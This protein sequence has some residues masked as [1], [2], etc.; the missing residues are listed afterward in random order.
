MAVQ[1]DYG[2]FGKHTIVEARYNGNEKI[3]VQVR[4]PTDQVIEGRKLF[5]A[6]DLKNLNARVDLINQ[7]YQVHVFNGT[8][9]DSYIN[10]VPFD[11]I[12]PLLWHL[13]SHPEFRQSLVKSSLRID[14]GEFLA[15]NKLPKH[16]EIFWLH[17]GHE[18]YGL[19][20]Y[21][22][23]GTFTQKQMHRIVLYGSFLEQLGHHN[24]NLSEASED[25]G[26]KKLSTNESILESFLMCPGYSMIESFSLI[27]DEGDARFDKSKLRV[28]RS[29][30]IPVYWTDYDGRFLYRIID[31]EHPKAED[32]QWE[33][34]GIVEEECPKCA[35]F[36]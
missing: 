28:C 33:L 15:K 8:N 31:P 30:D 11:G 26:D 36:R 34:E 2:V 12:N 9:E 7:P 13:H 18:K 21:V 23:N 4:L 6:K 25:F 22:P 32:I 29:H 10:N 27:V 17:P 24:P 19:F 35:E 5:S 3:S 1:I 16:P 14:Y 20:D